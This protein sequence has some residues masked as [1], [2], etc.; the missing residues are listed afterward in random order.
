MHE[1]VSSSGSGQRRVTKQALPDGEVVNGMPPSTSEAR[2]PLN[3]PE[4]DDT[5]V[6]EQHEES[7]SAVRSQKRQKLCQS[8]SDRPHIAI[9]PEIKREAFGT[10]P[11]ALRPSPVPEVRNE[12]VLPDTIN[13]NP[14]D[15]PI[16]VI[17][18]SAMQ[19][20]DQPRI[21]WDWNL[22]RGKVN[23]PYEPTVVN[24]W[25]SRSNVEFDSMGKEARRKYSH[26]GRIMETELGERL[27]DNNGYTFCTSRGLEC[28]RY[29]TAGALQITNPGDSCARC[30]MKAH[31][32]GCSLNLGKNKPKREGRSKSMA[33]FA[34]QNK[35]KSRLNT[36]F[37]RDPGSTAAM[38]MAQHPN[39]ASANVRVYVV[40]DVHT[41]Q[42][43]DKGMIYSRGEAISTALITMMP[44][45]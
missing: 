22:R 12:E 4:S 20:A 25:W 19:V 38:A 43:Q 27:D 9:E 15:V 35:A 14:Q 17:N 29:S 39:N 30:R 41:Q 1:V 36:P 26:I 10:T 3:N 33:P 31:V 34:P 16:S 28:W 6:P 21:P 18:F 7:P 45:E 13:E 42:V 40:R 2:S 23:T 32:G 37:H 24:K 44:L 5:L 11:L 8:V